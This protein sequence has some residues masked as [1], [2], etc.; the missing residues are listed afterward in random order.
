MHFSRKWLLRNMCGWKLQFL[1]C[2]QR[3]K[4]SGS[5]KGSWTLL[6]KSHFPSKCAKIRRGYQLRFIKIGL[7]WRH[8]P[9]WCRRECFDPHTTASQSCPK[10]EGSRNCNRS[11][12]WQNKPVEKC[13]WKLVGR[14]IFNIFTVATNLLPFP[15]FS[16]QINAED[17]R[18]GWK[19]VGKFD[20]LAKK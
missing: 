14:G 5:G 17:A 19:I 13:W 6:C 8:L 20:F 2:K 15:C 11:I 12:K 1:T 7:I 9:R 10:R 3:T 4:D 16:R 18:S